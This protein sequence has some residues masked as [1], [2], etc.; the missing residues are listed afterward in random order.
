MSDKPSISQ[1]I[2]FCFSYKFLPFIPFLSDIILPSSIQSLFVLG[3]DSSYPFYLFDIFIFLFFLIALSKDKIKIVKPDLLKLIIFYVLCVFFST[4]AN[5]IFHLFVGLHYCIDFILYAF[6]FRFAFYNKTEVSIVLMGFRFLI[7][8]LSIQLFLVY[9]GF[10]QFETLGNNGLMLRAGTTAGN[11]NM[12]SHLLYLLCFVSL[13]NLNNKIWH[14]III[15]VSGLGIFFTLCRGAI[16]AYALFV[17]CYVF[18]YIKKKKF[19]V[20]IAAALLFIGVFLSLNYY[21]HFEEV[22]E[23]R[24]EESLAYSGGDDY[25][26]GRTERWENVINTLNRNNTFF[27]GEGVASTG[28]HRTEV[29]SSKNIDAGKFSPHNVYIALLSETGIISLLIFLCIFLDSN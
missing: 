29:L 19:L 2:R 18:L 22:L 21:F 15:I 7:F 16:L 10:I 26:A 24:Q 20:K 6:L 17:V 13:F 12:V 3:K 5:N 27:W 1:V 28:M 25:S 8:F 14:V 4:I 23:A 9:F 11:S